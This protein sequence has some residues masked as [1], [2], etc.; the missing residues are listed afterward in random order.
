[1]ASLE[2]GASTNVLSIDEDA[3]DGSL[4]SDFFESLLDLVAISNFVKLVKLEL[5]ATTGEEGLGS[6]SEGAVGLGID[7]NLM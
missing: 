2:L 1:V 3:G 5:N 4:A 7:K 6:C